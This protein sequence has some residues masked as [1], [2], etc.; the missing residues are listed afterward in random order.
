[1]NSR[2]RS[3]RAAG[4]T[5]RGQPGFSQLRIV[6]N[7]RE[8]FNLSRIQ[9]RPPAGK[10]GRRYSLDA[11]LAANGASDV[12]GQKTVTPIS[13]RDGGRIKGFRIDTYVGTRH[14]VSRHYEDISMLVYLSDL[15]S[16]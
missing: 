10:G 13:L 4:E 3:P 2:L 9:P 6:T 5:E 1:M 8:N 12:H 11:E 16:V 14:P 15:A 7:C